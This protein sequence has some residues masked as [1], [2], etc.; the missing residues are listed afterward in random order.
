MSEIRLQSDIV[1]RFSELYP[2]KR[3]Q[4]FHVA[5]ERNHKL[6]AF[7][8]KAI[9]I[10]SGVS[11]LIY[12]NE[13][14]NEIGTFSREKNTFMLG[15]EVKEPGKSHKKDHIECQIDWGRTLE[16]N[17]GKWVLSTSVES[18]IEATLGNYSNCLSISDVEELLKKDKLKTIKF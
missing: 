1:R 16:R 8:A 14:P 18:A 11:D 6:Q 15:L 7:Q 5:N 12:F 3:G 17:G 10:F 2:E 9:G 13:K 4:L